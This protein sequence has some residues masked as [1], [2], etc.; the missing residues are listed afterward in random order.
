MSRIEESSGNRQTEATPTAHMSIHNPL[1]D[2]GR[3]ARDEFQFHFTHTRTREIFLRLAIWWVS[4]CG[5]LAALFAYV[6]PLDDVFV[7]VAI[8]GFSL[9]VC[10]EISGAIVGFLYQNG[11]TKALRVI[12]VLGLGFGAIIVGFVYLALG[13]ILLSGALMIGLAPSLPQ[14]LTP[15]IIGMYLIFSLAWAANGLAWV[16][17]RHHGDISPPPLGLLNWLS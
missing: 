6:N 11:A 8:G 10:L 2:F 16:E 15:A 12:G 14:A 5:L 9:F 13:G 7:A 1:T 3:T 4:S 17:Q